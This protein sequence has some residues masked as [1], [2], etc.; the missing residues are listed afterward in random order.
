VLSAFFIFESTLHLVM[1]TTPHDA[2]S[3]AHILVGK[4]KAYLLSWVGGSSP[5]TNTQSRR[6]V[7]KPL[8]QHNSTHY[9]PKYFDASQ[10]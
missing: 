9:N 3:E 6:Q 1:A 5:R 10:A 7:D 4:Y 8:Q 2:P